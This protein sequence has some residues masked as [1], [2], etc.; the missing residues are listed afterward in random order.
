MI[1]EWISAVGY[2]TRRGEFLWASQAVMFARL[3]PIASSTHVSE[4]VKKWIFSTLWTLQLRGCENANQPFRILLPQTS[5]IQRDM[6]GFLRILP[7]TKWTDF[8]PHVLP[9]LTFSQSAEL[10][11]V[12]KISHTGYSNT[13]AIAVRST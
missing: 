12:V 11:D 4:W 7:I 13:H 5:V 1:C 10:F 8:R 6:I 2:E 3:I 9:P